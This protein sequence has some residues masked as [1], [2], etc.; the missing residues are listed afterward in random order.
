MD[1]ADYWLRL[2]RRLCREF[3]G[4]DDARLRHHWCDGL[5]AGEFD[6]DAARPCVRG[7]AWCGRTGQEDWTFVLL[8]G[9]AV[10]SRQDIDWAALLPDENATGWLTPDPRERTMRIDPGSA[11]HGVG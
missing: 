5:V 3:A 2:E 11:Y 10:A 6:L 9:R 1:E 4:L 8:L 7:R